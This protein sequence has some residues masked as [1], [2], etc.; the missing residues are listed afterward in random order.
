M[1]THLHQI[2]L[3]TALNIKQPSDTGT[4]YKIKHTSSIR[5]CHF[6][7]ALIQIDRLIDFLSIFCTPCALG[8]YDMSSSCGTYFLFRKHS[9]SFFGPLLH[10]SQSCFSSSMCRDCKK[11]TDLH[12]WSIFCTLCTIYNTSYSHGRFFPE[13]FTTIL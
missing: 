9:Y 13:L 4:L 1:R 11:L 12:V 2:S 7:N 5:P 6:I 8:I 3:Q 10:L